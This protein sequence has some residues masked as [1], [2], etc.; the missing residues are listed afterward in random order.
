M[1]VDKKKI[2]NTYDF[3][4]ILDE[5]YICTHIVLLNIKSITLP[6]QTILRNGGV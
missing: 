5:F 1:S 4:V 6:T 2:V 3:T